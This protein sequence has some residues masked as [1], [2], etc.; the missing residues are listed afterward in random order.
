MTLPSP[1]QTFTASRTSRMFRSPQD[2]VF[3]VEGWVVYRRVHA[4][5]LT[6]DFFYQGSSILDQ[7]ITMNLPIGS[8]TAVYNGGA[9]YND[10]T[11]YGETARERLSRQDFKAAGRGSFFQVRASVTGNDDFE[12]HEIG[13]RFLSAET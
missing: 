1:T 11:V 13:L 4:V 7:E 3:N 12:I 8:L 2:D 6:I 9:D 5:T 10:G